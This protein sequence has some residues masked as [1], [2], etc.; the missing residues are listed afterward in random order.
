MELSQGIRRIGFRRWYERELIESHLYLM[1]WFL[2]LVL[3]LACLEGFSF[4]TPGWEPVVRFAGMTLGVVLCMWTLQRY[5]AML[6]Y[7]L[8]VAERSV[9]RNC[10]AYSA[11]VLSERKAGPAVRQRGAVDVRCVKCGNEWTID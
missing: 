8:H 3:V 9:C 6:A 5:I 7:A 10:R 11:F 4:K 2:S 1:S